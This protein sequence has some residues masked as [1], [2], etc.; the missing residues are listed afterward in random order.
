MEEFAEESN[1][2]SLAGVVQAVFDTSGT[3]PAGGK[4]NCRFYGPAVPVGRV[5]ARPS[6][7]E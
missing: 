3:N 1:A 7:K 5:V 4:R 2:G 6:A